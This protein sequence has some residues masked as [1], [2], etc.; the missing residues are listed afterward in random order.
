MLFDKSTFPF[1]FGSK[2]VL[3][4]TQLLLIHDETEYYFMFLRTLNTHK[5]SQVFDIVYNILL[6]I[7]MRHA[8]SKNSDF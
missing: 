3:S 7:P 5:K 1:R 4:W 2:H 8:L 6:N